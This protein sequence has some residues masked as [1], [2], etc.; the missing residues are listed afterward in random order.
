MEL[1]IEYT[2]NTSDFMTSCF[3]SIRDFLSQTSD[4]TLETNVITYTNYSYFVAKNTTSDLYLIFI[5]A[6]NRVGL[7]VATSYDNTKPILNQKDL[8]YSMQNSLSVVMPTIG[9]CNKLVANY[10]STDETVMFSGLK[11]LSYNFTGQITT[12]YLTENMCFGN[13]VKYGSWVNS[14]GFWYGGDCVHYIATTSYA[15]TFIQNDNRFEC[16]LRIDMD[17]AKN[18]P[19]VPSSFTDA[20]IK[21]IVDGKQIWAVTL[22]DKIGTFIYVPLEVSINNIE[23]GLPSYWSIMS[24]TQFEKGHTSN[25]LNKI[26][27]IMRL[28]FMVKRDPQVLN[29]YS[30]VGYTNSV[31]FVNMYNMST[32]RVI[33]GTFPVPLDYYNCFQCGIRRDY[34]D[35]KG[36]IGLAFKMEEQN[37][38]EE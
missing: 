21:A 4:Y 7:T 19:V 11:Q 22:T 35:F 20:T 16:F 30:C 2:I 10:N 31:N 18:R 15:W 17:N 32:N 26:S 8:I 37:D 6:N 14:G 24:L 12:Q 3:D 29:D 27:I 9:L 28:F 36:Y 25:D 38:E 33:N 13:V 34:R 5:Y 23:K 1:R